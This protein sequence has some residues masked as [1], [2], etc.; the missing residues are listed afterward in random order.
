MNQKG[1]KM[2]DKQSEIALN[3]VNYDD[4]KTEKEKK[5]AYRIAYQV[6]IER[7]WEADIKA[8]E[9]ESRNL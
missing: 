5:E 6:Q 8:L 9:W 4:C 3:H 1:Y 2:I 7:Q